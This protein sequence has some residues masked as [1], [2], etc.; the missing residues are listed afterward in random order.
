MTLA[1]GVP[2]VWFGV[3]VAL[4]PIVGMVMAAGAASAV[5]AASSEAESDGA[6]APARDARSGRAGSP[7]SA[8][9]GAS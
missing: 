1:L 5:K 2:L 7:R 4:G 6:T 8:P 9:L 3:S